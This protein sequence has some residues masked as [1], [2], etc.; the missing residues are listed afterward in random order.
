MRTAFLI[1]LALICC[2]YLST[3]HAMGD[4]ISGKSK[5]AI[6]EGCH[7]QKSNNPLAPKLGGQP[8]NY[9]LQQLIKFK[10]GTRESP[11]MKGMAAAL[12]TEQDME[13][14]AAYYASQPYQKISRN[15]LTAISETGESLYKQ[16]CVMCH[17]EL[18][19]GSK[20]KNIDPLFGGRQSQD[21]S[22]T[23]LI[24]G[25]PQLY[26][27]KTLKEFRA[28]QRVSGKDYMMDMA[29]EYMSDDQINMVASYLSS[30]SGGGITAGSLAKNN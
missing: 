6:C 18:G 26:L 14:V 30:L 20:S 29:L 5:A 10:N 12:Q 22:T 27:V 3:A 21:N 4:P 13:D 15:K 25:Q 17:G 28:K 23:P 8:Y 7:G 11:I 24:G 16:L 19:D 9:S 2:T 1:V